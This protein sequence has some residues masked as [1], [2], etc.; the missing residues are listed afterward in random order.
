MN[1]ATLSG[2][3]SASATATPTSTTTLPSTSLAGTTTMALPST[4]SGG[5]TTATT[6]EPYAASAIYT[7]GVN[8]LVSG[9]HALRPAVGLGSLARSITC[10]ALPVLLP[11]FLVNQIL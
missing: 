8:G 7:P 1:T 11:Y 2:E 5:T 6:A 9:A 10:L 4:T 3:G